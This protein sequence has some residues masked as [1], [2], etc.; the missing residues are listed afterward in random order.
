MKTAKMVVQVLGLVV[1]FFVVAMGTLRFQHSND[2]GPSILFPG[3]ALVSGELHT[4]PEPDWSFT[5]DIQTIELELDDSDSSR[6][7]WIMDADG[8]AYVASGYMGNFLGRLWKHWAVEAYE[9]SGRAVVRIDDTRYERQ[10]VRIHE[11]DV[12]DGVAASMVRK[13]MGGNP[14]P[15]AI[16]GVRAAIESGDTWIFEL[17]PRGE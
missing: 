2:D 6:L 7:I 9:G 10:L 16:A 15:E 3:G 5:S 13:Y 8:K 1:I 4:G 14:T 17:A 12:L 11:G